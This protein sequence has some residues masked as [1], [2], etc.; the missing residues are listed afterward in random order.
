[1]TDAD[2]ASI[3]P[4]W[5][6]NVAIKPVMH[7]TGSRILPILDLVRKFLDACDDGQKRLH[8]LQG[9]LEARLDTRI[10]GEWEICWSVLGKK[11]RDERSRR[12]VS[13][14]HIAIRFLLL[15][16]TVYLSRMKIGRIMC[17]C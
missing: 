16:C 5:F 8:H 15:L 12:K 11:G 14:V 6:H 17:L 1:M 9:P 4:N 7:Q 10:P 3:G 13:Y 2:L